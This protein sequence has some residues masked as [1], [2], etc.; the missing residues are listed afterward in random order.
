MNSGTPKLHVDS[1]A[2]NLPM[3]RSCLF[4]YS[5]PTRSTSYFHRCRT[6]V[7]SNIESRQYPIKRP[8]SNNGFKS[9][10]SIQTNSISQPYQNANQ[11]KPS[12]PIPNQSS[13]LKPMRTLQHQ[14]MQ[15][16]KRTKDGSRITITSN[17]NQTE[18]YIS[19]NP[20][21]VSFTAR[22]TNKA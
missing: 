14:R 6:N 1:P 12:T 7:T 18:F 4:H 21:H 17:R 3:D 16:T 2:P 20:R 8:Q 22:S 5:S 13:S 9:S 15:D 11:S 10:E 19:M